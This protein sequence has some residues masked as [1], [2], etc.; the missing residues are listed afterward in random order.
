MRAPQLAEFCAAPW[1]V[2]T[3]PMT[4]CPAGEFLRELSVHDEG[5]FLAIAIWVGEVKLCH[6]FPNT[7]PEVR[8]WAARTLMALV[9]NAQLGLA[10]AITTAIGQVLT[11]RQQACAF[12]PSEDE[13]FVHHDAV[14]Q[15]A[16][17]L[18]ETLDREFDE[19]VADRVQLGRGLAGSR[20]N[21]QRFCLCEQPRHAAAA[22]VA[23]EACGEL[24]AAVL[25]KAQVHGDITGTASV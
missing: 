10:A 15:V 6:E 2:F 8:G 19:G 4:D 12:A 5:Y 9:R 1:W 13:A 16:G 18:A 11:G 22:R 25:Q 24:G 3:P 21:Q 23:I 17:R 7:R 20:F 14:E